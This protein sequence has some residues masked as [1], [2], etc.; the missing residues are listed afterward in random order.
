[1]SG[2][3]ITSPRERRPVTRPGYCSH[4]ERPVSRCPRRGFTGHAWDCVRVGQD[5]D[6]L[7]LPVSIDALREVDAGGVWLRPVKIGCEWDGPFRELMP[8][9]VSGGFVDVWG[10]PGTLRRATLT[11]AGICR[12][13]ERC[14]ADYEE[15]GMHNARGGTS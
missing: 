12:L 9:L 15:L 11:S 5:A 3:G 13:H 1:M 6:V 2:V 8:G 10:P 4:C 7:S 14:F